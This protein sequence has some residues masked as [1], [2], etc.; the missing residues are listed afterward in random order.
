[1]STRY[2]DVLKT[3]VVRAGSDGFSVQVKVNGSD[4]PR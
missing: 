1:M 3:A 4:A 2:I